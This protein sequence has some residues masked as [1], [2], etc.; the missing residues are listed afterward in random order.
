MAV[1]LSPTSQEACTPHI[2]SLP[3]VALSNAPQKPAI[4]TPLHRPNGT[5]PIVKTGTA[6][7][8]GKAAEVRTRRARPQT[9]QGNIHYREAHKQ[10]RDRYAAVV[11]W[12]DTYGAGLPTLTITSRCWPPGLENSFFLSSSEVGRLWGLSVR[13]QARRREG[14][15]L[16]RL[17]ER[18][19]VPNRKGGVLGY[20]FKNRA[21]W[22]S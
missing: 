6:N 12:V 2:H 16:L 20:G 3:R 19:M 4:C 14:V 9:S 10:A 18:G 13:A 17:L 8:H 5:A 1:A 22:A 11:K 7:P 21:F 15:S